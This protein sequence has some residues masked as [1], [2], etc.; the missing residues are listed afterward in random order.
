MSE[1]FFPRAEERLDSSFVL[2]YWDVVLFKILKQQP[3][4]CQIGPL[5]SLCDVA[6]DYLAALF[7]TA[8]RRPAWR[9]IQIL[10]YHPQ[11]RRQDV[12]ELCPC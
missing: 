9:P 1:R 6:L 7:L 2:D 4:D 10:Y 8:E 5:R 11:H 12:Y 3:N